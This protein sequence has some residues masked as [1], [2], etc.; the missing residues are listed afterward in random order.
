MR[1]EH[2]FKCP[3]KQTTV[4]SGHETRVGEAK[5]CGKVTR[6]TKNGRA[7]PREGISNRDNPRDE[8]T[9]CAL[10]YKYRSRDFQSSSNLTT[11]CK[12]IQYYESYVLAGQ[13]VSKLIFTFYQILQRS[14]CGRALNSG[15]RC[16]LDTVSNSNTSIKK[17][18]FFLFRLLFSFSLLFLSLLFLFHFSILLLFALSLCFLGTRVLYK[19]S[20]SLYHYKFLSAAATWPFLFMAKRTSPPIHRHQSRSAKKCLPRVSNFVR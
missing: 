1:G 3:Q 5:G 17:W 12:R 13:H 2:V 10:T 20:R 18:E 16:G 11:I 4:W 15:S 6:D 14:W 8:D 7:G 9:L 19:K